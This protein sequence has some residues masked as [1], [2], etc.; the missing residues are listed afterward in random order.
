MHFYNTVLQ[1]E[2]F[3]LQGLSMHSFLTIE[4]AYPAGQ[5]VTQVCSYDRYPGLQLQ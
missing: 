5:L 1:L 2:Q 4:A 3:A